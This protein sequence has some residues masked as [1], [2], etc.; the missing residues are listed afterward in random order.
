MT[1]VITSRAGVPLHGGEQMAS[2]VCLR[3]QCPG[4]S[5][6]STV[7]GS[8]SHQ[9]RQSSH[10]REQHF[11][12]TEG[13]GSA[14]MAGMVLCGQQLVSWG[15]VLVGPSGRGPVPPC[16]GDTTAALT[17][18]HMTHTLRQ[19]KGAHMESGTGK[20]IPTQGDK[21]NTGCEAPC[22]LERKVPGAWL[23]LCGPTGVERLDA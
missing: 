6:H 13:A 11:T 18:S 5:A 1:P 2:T 22:L 19:N 15:Y 7:H 14:S 3:G 4:T 17:Q 20:D 10:W 8:W 23:H 21:P 12:H 9:E 16:R